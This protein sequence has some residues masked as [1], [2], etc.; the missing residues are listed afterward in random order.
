MEDNIILNTENFKDE[1]I[2]LI[3][4]SNLPVSLIYYIIKDLEREL[5]DVYKQSVKIA[6]QEQKI[7]KEQEKENK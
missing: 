6:L 2:K 1:I 7:N 3:K 5:E 4:N